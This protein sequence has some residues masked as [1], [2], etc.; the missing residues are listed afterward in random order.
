MAVP[1]VAVGSAPPDPSGVGVK[2]GRPRR[3]DADDA[4]LTAALELLADAGVAGLSMDVLAQRAGV[5]KA[6]IYRRWASKEAL[7]LDALRTSN[8][9]I[10][11]PD[12][13]NVHDDLIAYT[14]AVVERFGPDRAS[15]VLP[16]LIEASCYDDQLR[17]SL[18]DYL[19]GRQTTIRLILQR[20]IER[21]ELGGDTDVDLVV[22]LILGPF[23]YRHLLTGAP[24][25]RDFAH[26]LVE[27]ALR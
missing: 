1:I 18:D 4:I 10:P 22:D 5:G 25:D 8:A 12:E 19:R 21:G 3:A 13:G 26:R 15:D 14:D 9:P 17:S 24:L 7:I 23:F 16:H 6:T 11:V 2:R 27:I 20:G